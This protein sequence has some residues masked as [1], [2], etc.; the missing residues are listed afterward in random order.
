MDYT[1]QLFYRWIRLKIQLEQLAKL[2]PISEGEVWWC[3]IGKNIGIEINGKH[4]SFSRPVIIYKKLSRYGF[5][6]IPLSTQLHQGSWYVPFTF[7]NKKQVA[8]LAQI[9]VISVFRLYDRMGV[10]SKGDLRQIKNSFLKLY[11]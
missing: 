10:L 7:Q 1:K 4:N 11:K 8:V 5:L 6:A 2:P 3:S 9:R